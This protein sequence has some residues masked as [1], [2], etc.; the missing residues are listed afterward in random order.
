MERPGTEVELTIWRWGER[1]TIDV[2]LGKGDAGADTAIRGGGESE[3]PSNA[4]GLA[5]EPLEGEQRRRY[6]NAEG[7]V[8]IAEVESD[9]AYRAGIRRGQLILMINNQPVDSIEDF[10][11]IVDDIK[12]GAA[13]AL[14]IQQPGRSEERRVGKERRWRW[15]TYA[16]R[17]N[18]R[19]SRTSKVVNN[20]M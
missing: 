12:P 8:I 13:V 19:A 20:R 6:E 3:T 10:N 5:V 16:F 11:R 1:H 15:R 9:R 2:T 14:L 7:G 18:I 4:L 17:D